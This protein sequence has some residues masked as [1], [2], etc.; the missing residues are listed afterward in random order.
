MIRYSTVL[1]L[2]AT[3]LLNSAEIQ[4]AE[5]QADPNQEAADVLTLREHEDFKHVF[6][7]INPHERAVRVQKIDTSCACITT[8]L[9]KYFLIPEE[10]TTLSVQVS[11][12]RSSGLR[13][14]KVW[15]YVT[16]PELEAIEIISEW[17]VVPDVAVDL[18]KSDPSKRPENTKYRDIYR[19]ISN[20]KPNEAKRLKKYVRLSTPDELEGGF[21]V[22]P[23]YDGK[24]WDFSTKTLDSKTVLLIAKARVSDEDLEVGL[25]Q[26]TV[27]LKTNQPHKAEFALQFFTNVDP[28]AGNKEQAINNFDLPPPK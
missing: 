11:N 28:N 27:T 9:G 1:A 25:F 20:V 6:T 2:L 21:Q 4:T 17:I 22:T 10:K 16:D 8:D 18:I 13:K 5:E 12:E 15:L 7:V 24:I 14:Y 3:L 19:Y 23:H 26:E